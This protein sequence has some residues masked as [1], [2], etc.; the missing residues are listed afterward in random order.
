MGKA[1]ELAQLL[2]AEGSVRFENL[3]TVV[4]IG[5][6]AKPNWSETDTS[7]YS[8]IANKPNIPTDATI[9]A[10][11]YV[12]TDTNTQ[13]SDSDIATM[14]YIKT[15]TNTQLSDSDITTMGY[16][17]TALQVET[18]TTLPASPTAGVL[19]LVEA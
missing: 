6:V 11:G 4:G 14:G 5:E 19:Y 2:N 13:L 1:F 18:V 7:K 15:D 17:K 3:A 10:M 12:K 16:I 9:A 8:F